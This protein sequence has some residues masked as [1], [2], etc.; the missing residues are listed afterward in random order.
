MRASPGTTLVRLWLG[1]LL[2]LC[3]AGASEEARGQGDHA[4]AADGD[5]LLTRLEGLTDHVYGLVFSRDG[6]RV[7]AGDTDGFAAVW[8]FPEGKLIRRFRTSLPEDED[9]HVAIYHAMTFNRDGSRLF[10][11]DRLG[12]IHIWDVAGEEEPKVIRAHGQAVNGT[13]IWSVNGM[14]LSPDGER[15]ATCGSDGE[16][17]LWE[18]PGGEL[19]A[20]L[21][22]H[23]WAV[24][25]VAFSP[26]GRSLIVADVRGRLQEVAVDGG[27]VLARRSPSKERS[28]IGGLAVS[29]DGQQVVSN[30]YLGRIRVFER[31]GLREVRRF[32]PPEAGEGG[33]VYRGNDLA[34]HPD[35]RLLAAAYRHSD[36]D[37]GLVVWWDL[38]SGK[39]LRREEIFFAVADNVRFSPDGRYLVAAGGAEWLA[40][41]ETEQV[42]AKKASSD[43]PRPER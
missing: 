7:A 38:A 31:P 23:R 13:R 34:V 9:E 15:L 40:V 42:R 4:A 37:H 28:S 14:A 1:V 24:E 27:K 36:A 17:R 30:E 22:S 26:D 11:G 29:K 33:G 35:G 6:K 25:R 5:R 39:E 10:A 2:A 41:F 16:V 20:T 43:R 19:A 21:L 8:E 3:L 32:G 12:R 18:L